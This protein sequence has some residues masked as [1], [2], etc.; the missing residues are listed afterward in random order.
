VIDACLDKSDVEITPTQGADNPAM[1]MSLVA[2]LRGVSLIPAYLQA[3]MPTA[4]RIQG[5]SIVPCEF[6]EHAARDLLT[7]RRWI[8]VFHVVL[9]EQVLTDKRQR[10]LPCR[11]PC[12]A[13]V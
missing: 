2:S 7:C 4:H 13:G 1:V 6:R 5:G 9:A 8:A 12:K 11:L 3:L 10:E